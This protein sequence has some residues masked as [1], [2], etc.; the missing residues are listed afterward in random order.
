M[1]S[2][3]A[4]VLFARVRTRLQGRAAGFVEQEVGGPAA[5]PRP[6]LPP[7]PPFLSHRRARCSSWS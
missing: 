7:S 1:I 4:P 2:A 3:E 5:C 6:P